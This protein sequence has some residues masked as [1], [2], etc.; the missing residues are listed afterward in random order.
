[1]IMTAG[2]LGTM[3]LTGSYYLIG[4]WRINTTIL[5]TVPIIL[6]LVVFIFYVEDTPLFLL[7]QNN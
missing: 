6:T 2:T 4:N 7:K 5:Q 1:M 3:F